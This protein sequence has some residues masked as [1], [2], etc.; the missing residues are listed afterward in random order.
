MAAVCRRYV[1]SGKIMYTNTFP[2]VATCVYVSY[3][4]NE[5]FVPE[6]LRKYYVTML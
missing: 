6:Q 1:E 5:F 2:H 4:K 3:R